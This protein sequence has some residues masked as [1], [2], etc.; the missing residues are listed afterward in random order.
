[1]VWIAASGVTKAADATTGEFMDAV[2]RAAPAQNGED[3]LRTIV[4]GTASVTGEAFFRA[5]VQKLAQALGVRYAFV[6]EFTAVKTRVRTLAFWFDDHFIDNFEYDLPGTPCEGVLAGEVRCYPEG[7]CALF[8]QEHELVEMSAESYLAIPLI[9]SANRVLGHLAVIDVKSMHAAPRDMSIFRIFGAR[10]AAELDCLRA[11]QALARSEERY[12]DLFD[13]APDVYLSVGP[14]RLI[15]KANRRAAELFGFPLERLI[16]KDVFDLA[17]DTPDGRP[18]AQ[19]AFERFL[20]G[21]ETHGQEIEMRKADGAQLWISLSVHPIMDLQGRA[22]ATR[23]ILVDVTER[24]RI[25]EAL[26]KS[27]Q[28]LAGI[29][30]T[31]MDAIITID[32][33][34]TVTLF[35]VSAERVFKC[36]SA[37][38]IG[39]PFDRFLSKQFRKLLDDN[40]RAIGDKK[41]NLLQVWTPEGLTALRANGEEFPIE[42]TISRLEIGGQKYYTVILRDVN[43]RKHAEEELRRLRQEKT[44][45]QEEIRAEHNFENIVCDATSMKKVCADVEK[46]ARTD[47]TVLIIGETG[48]GKELIAH[49]LHNLSSRKDKP[50]IKMN[51]AAL[52]SELIESE[53][54][55]HEKGAFTGAIAQ[56]IGRFELADGGTLFLD[57]V[58]ELSPQAQA[59]LLRVLQDQ[60]FERV[61]GAKRIRVNVRVIAATNRNLAEIVGAGGFRSDLFYRLNVFPVQVPPLRERRTDIPL[62]ARYFLARLARK[63]GK[64]LEDIDADS[65]EKLIRYAW[66]GNIRELQ[67]VIERA[68]ILTQGPLVQIEDSLVARVTD[69]K[70]AFNGG[71]SSLS[72]VEREHILRVLVECNWVVEGERGAAA[73]LGL[74]SSTLRFRMQK[75]GIKK[76]KPGESS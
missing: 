51:C 41:Q 4:E 31:A 64:P 63:L 67:N 66:P 55:G 6:S 59:K 58:G 27:E 13:L 45:L 30:R 38:A 9:D 47:S 53:L 24:K 40:L 29:L 22:V 19:R 17:A 32:E 68:A 57:E 62:L 49:A 26:Q 7:I 33:L 43:D 3:L 23:S 56:R 75:L 2:T 50:L 1:M 39:Q 76:P 54:F 46:V 74:N 70:P 25:E 14:D 18:K 8:P 11:E 65:M 16:G 12:R 28:R 52:P 15:R 73:V 72:E 20:A 42:A 10:A 5:L 44:Y 35:N 69:D 71:G 36:S 21:E 60:E 37:W 34:R 61:G 48:T